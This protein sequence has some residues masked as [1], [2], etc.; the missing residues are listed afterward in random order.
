MSY[1]TDVACM[2]PKLNKWAVT[3]CKNSMDREDIVMSAVLKLLE[4]EKSY[5]SCK[6]KENL[7]LEPFARCVLQS[8]FID[9]TRKA[10]WVIDKM[11][12]AVERNYDNEAYRTI[13]DIYAIAETN[14]N[15]RCV[16]LYAEGYGYDEISHSE[17]MSNDAARAR[18][19]RGR[20][21]LIERF[22]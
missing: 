7:K 3:M 21:Y 9:H 16:L 2:M 20:K 14:S 8:C 17:H 18:V 19:S 1:A 15:V 10:K 11:E 4:S 13:K 22:C 12:E 5:L 6:R